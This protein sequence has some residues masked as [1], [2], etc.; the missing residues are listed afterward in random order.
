M[1]V[2]IVGMDKLNKRLNTI[3]QAHEK[4]GA[5]SAAHL[6][7]KAQTYPPVRKQAQPFKTDKSRRYFFA[8][9]RDGRIEVPYR[10]GSSPGS[11]KLGSR[12]TVIKDGNRH[13]VVNNTSYGPQVMGSERQAPY[14]RGNWKTE[15]QIAREEAP[16]VGHIFARHYRQ[17]MK[18]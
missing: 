15:T 12:W 11:Q 10:R 16:T 8:A 6:K 4:A 9:L 1:S 17:A 7:R 14:H 13:R 3:A 2:R 18:G 5:E